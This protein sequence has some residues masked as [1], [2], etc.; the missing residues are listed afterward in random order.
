VVEQAHTHHSATDNNHPRMRLHLA[1]P[2][3]THN[4][5]K[6]SA[7]QGSNGLGEVSQLE[8]SCYGRTINGTDFFRHS[9]R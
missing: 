9:N 5:Q 8:Q 2:F 1:L 4:C 3:S 6:L 7:A